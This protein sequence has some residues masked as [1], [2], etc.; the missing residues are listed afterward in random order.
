[1]CGIQKGR[2][3][4]ARKAAS[5]SVLGDF[6][7][8]GAERAARAAQIPKDPTVLA[9]GRGFLLKASGTS[10][11]TYAG[12]QT[13]SET[14]HGNDF[15]GCVGF[16]RLTSGSAGTLRGQCQGLS[17]EGESVDKG[18]SARAGG[19]SAAEFVPFKTCFSI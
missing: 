17:K 9:R 16:G 14:G 13:A 6:C 3:L 8:R 2:Q 19:G 5:R 11:V 18:S 7:A 15:A 1:M 4:G 12:D 10:V